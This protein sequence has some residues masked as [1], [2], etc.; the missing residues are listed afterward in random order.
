MEVEDV[1]VD[2]KVN[3]DTFSPKRKM[4]QN[5]LNY[6]YNFLFFEETDSPQCQEI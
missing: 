2:F 5:G 3:F 1:E 4:T 6:I